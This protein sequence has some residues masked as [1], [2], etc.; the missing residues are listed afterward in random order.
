MPHRL[1]IVDAEEAIGHS[2]SRLFEGRG[3]AA[4]PKRTAAELGDALVHDGSG[5][6][7]ALAR[8]MILAAVTVLLA[9]GRS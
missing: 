4:V 7:A 8:A 9:I 2:I 3:I 5:A 1:L 6:R